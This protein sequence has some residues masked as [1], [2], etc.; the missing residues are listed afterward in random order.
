MRDVMVAPEV[1]GPEFTRSGLN[2]ADGSLGAEV[3]FVT[4]EF[5]GARERMLNPEA[6]VFWPDEY[7]DHG[8]WMDGWE[9]RRR[10]TTGHDWSI[11]RLAMPGVL[12]GVDFDTSF[13]SGNFPPAA[14]LDACYCPGSDPDESTEWQPLIPATPLRGD[15]HCFCE[16]VSGRPWTHLRLHLYPDGGLARLRVYGKPHR[17]WK[18]LDTSTAI[19]LLALE[20]GGDQVAWSDA[21]YGEPRKLLR[22]GRGINMGDGWETRRRREPGND[23]CILA[24]CH[25]GIAGRIEVDTAHFK[26]NFP[27]T[28]S[29]QAACVEAGASTASSLI[30]QSMFWQTLMPEQPLTADAIHEFAELADLGPTTH[31]RFNMIPDGGVSRLRLFGKPVP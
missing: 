12:M 23:W 8:K 5:F 17:D 14:A 10:R 26:G 21:H 19:N 30:T 25:K 15:D 22:P 1:D 28:C 13:F 18:N 9:T 7:D 4:D 20:N 6:P 2:L 3:L 31:I 11:I 16:I 27:A 24:L 29:V